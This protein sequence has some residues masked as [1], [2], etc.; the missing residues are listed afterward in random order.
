VD[1]YPHGTAIVEQGRVAQ[2]FPGDLAFTAFCDADPIQ[3]IDVAF[4]KLPGPR[5]FYW[6]ILVGHVFLLVVSLM[7]TFQKIK[8]RRGYLSKK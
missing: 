5:W 6:V 8:V 7:K 4:A 2:P 3:T 1:L